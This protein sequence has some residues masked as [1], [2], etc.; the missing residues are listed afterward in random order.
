[1]THVVTSGGRLSRKPTSEQ[2]VLWT[3]NS[4]R[5]LMRKKACDCCSHTFKERSNRTSLDDCWSR[6]VRRAELSYEHDNYRTPGNA[7]GDAQS[8]NSFKSKKTKWETCV[9]LGFLLSSGNCTPARANSLLL[10]RWTPWTTLASWQVRCWSPSKNCIKA[11][12]RPHCPVALMSWWSARGMAPT[13]AHRS[14]CA[15]ESWVCCAPKRKWWV[16]F[17]FP[18]PFMIVVRLNRNVLDIVAVIYNIHVA[19]IILIRA[20]SPIKL[21]RSHRCE[22]VSVLSKWIW[23]P[24][25]HS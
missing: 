9:G 15:L 14:M 16:F 5:S 1:M 21:L 8:G 17:S 25:E 10:C 12:I 11:S 23:R 6:S 2:R 4:K 19:W 3:N 7:E 22:Y 18:F 20:V 24:P 13:S